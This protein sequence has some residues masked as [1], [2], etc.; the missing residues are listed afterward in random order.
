M[1]Q[2]NESSPRPRRN[3]QQISALL[4]KFNSSGLT[5]SDF[6]ERHQINENNLRKWISRAKQ[7]ANKKEIRRSAF[8]AVQVTTSE[9]VLFAEVDGIRIYQPV[10]ASYL[11]ELKG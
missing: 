10:T 9:S 1:E 6:C 11:K 3:S 2:V 5:V 4:A 7:K 8:A